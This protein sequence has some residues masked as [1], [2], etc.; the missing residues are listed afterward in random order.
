MAANTRKNP[1]EWL[2]PPLTFVGEAA[3]LLFQGARRIFKRPIETK[4]TLDQMAFVGVASVPIVA[5]TTFFSGAVMSLYISPLLLKI[6]AANMAGGT[7]TLTVARELGPVVAGIMVTARCGSAMAAQ[8]GS[9]SV[10]EQ[11]DAL[12][13]L[14]VNPYS[15]LVVPRLLA[16]IL[17]LPM[18]GIVGFFCGM[19]GGMVVSTMYGIPAQAYFRSLSYWLVPWDFVGGLIKTAVFG[20]II[21]V[22]A[23]Q[24]G[25]RTTGG[26]VGVGKAT[27]H[28]V[29]ISMVLIYVI[30]Y[31][32]ASWFF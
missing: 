18:L 17:M 16:G 14:G 31:F 21:T 2:L 28:A 25:M 3:I 22:V 7:V 24:Q 11:L 8:I 10:T 23:C 13:A 30:N 4:E 29:V 20:M 15:Y 1:F 6:G 19:I 32:L 27:T 26:A 9:M 5:M 12:R